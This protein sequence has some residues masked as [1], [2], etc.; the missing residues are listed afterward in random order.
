MKSPSKSPPPASSC[1]TAKGGASNAANFKPTNF[2]RITEADKD[3]KSKSKVGNQRK[4]QEENEIKSNA[5]KRTA[6]SSLNDL[7]KEPAPC[8]PLRP[9]ITVLPTA[10]IYV[11]GIFN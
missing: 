11:A 8:S 6:T 3:M 5:Q 7:Q 9:P 1:K 10:W 2:Y 4:N